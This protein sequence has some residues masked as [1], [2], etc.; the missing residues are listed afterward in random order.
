[1]FKYIKDPIYDSYL[2]F[3]LEEYQFIDTTEFK[4]LKNIKQ[5]GSLD[6]V[7]PGATHNRFSHS[8][9]VACLAESYVKSIYENSDIRLNDSKKKIIRNLKIAGLYHDIGH[10]PFS[11][12]FDN[13]VLPKICG[14]NFLEHEKRSCNILENVIKSLKL[15]NFN[16]YDIDFIK[17]AIEPEINTEDYTSQIIANKVN[18]ID[19]DKFDYLVRDPYY[20]GFNYNFNYQRLYNKTKLIDSKIYYHHTVANDIYDL[21]FTRYKFHREIYNHKTVKSIELMIA[22][23]L[24]EANDVYNFGSIINT[25]DFLDLDDTIL[26]RIKY[27]PDKSLDNCRHLLNRITKRNLYKKI[28]DISSDDIELAND[29]LSD[30]FPDYKSDDFHVVKLHFDFCNKN[31]NP[32]SNIQFYNNSGVIN[33]DEVNIRKLIPTDFRENQIIIYKK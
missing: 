20:I 31:N 32:F 18:S 24:L 22:D 15:K 33:H 9:G 29:Y 21:Y 4:R 11:H 19:V 27:N 28:F 8:L 1:M 3:S 7:F 13:I 6:H 14:N 25:E 17:N 16:G 12:V 2:K 26:T 10:G 23:T 30:N 5:L